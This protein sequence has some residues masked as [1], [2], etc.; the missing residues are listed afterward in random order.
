MAELDERVF[1]VSL[2]F[3]TIVFPITG[4]LRE[5]LLDTIPAPTKYGIEQEVTFMRTTPRTVYPWHRDGRRAAAINILV[6]EPDDGHICEMIDQNRPYYGRIPYDRYAP[7]L[8]DV[9][10]L[11]QVQNQSLTN[12][13]YII[14]MGF[15]LPEH[16]YDRLVQWYDE[17][18][19]LSG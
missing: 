6:S 8:V 11:H 1:N 14:T 5:Y 7:F 13:R 19:Y 10:V 17:Q 12:N 18:G 3:M 2:S 15:L 9:Q 4:D 16:S